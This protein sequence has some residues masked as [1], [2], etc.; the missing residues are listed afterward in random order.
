M[1]KI[2]TALFL[3][4]FLALPL[5]AQAQDAQPAA[6]PGYDEAELT[7]LANRLLDPDP[8]VADEATRDLKEIGSPAVPVLI[9]ALADKRGEMRYKACEVLAELRDGRAVDALMV[10]LDDREH[11]GTSIAS[12]AAKAL[13]RLA[14]GRA[15]RPLLPLVDS[16]DVELQYNVIRALGYLRGYEA[17]PKLIP[18]LKDQAKT[19]Y[20]GLVR[21]A[22]AEALGRLKAKDAVADLAALLDDTAEEV[23]TGM[24]VAYFAARALERITGVNNGS[25]T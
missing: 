19:F 8:F 5:S 6:G 20:D 18:R 14:D 21:C 13:G 4:A 3:A 12:A 22:A 2:Q 23:Y 24:P 1:H 9:K 17:I 7:E 25:L 11:P 16:E 10:L 15:V